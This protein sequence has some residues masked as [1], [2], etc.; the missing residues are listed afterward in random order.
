[1]FNNREAGRPPCLL[2]KVSVIDETPPQQSHG[3]VEHG[4]IVAL[5]AVLA[6]GGLVVFGPAISDLLDNLSGETFVQA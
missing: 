1:M 3:L 2:P 4:L 6:V 5:I